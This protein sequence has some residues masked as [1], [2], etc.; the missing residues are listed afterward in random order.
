MDMEGQVR[1]PESGLWLSLGFV[2]GKS[3]GSQVS[4]Q[5]FFLSTKH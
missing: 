1:G 4:A 3:D 5:A 2:G